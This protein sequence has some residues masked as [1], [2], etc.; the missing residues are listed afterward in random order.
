MIPLPVAGVEVPAG[1]VV[2]LGLFV[3]ALAGFFGVG[4]G[5]LLTPM[6]NALLGIPYGVAVGSSL[7]QMV[8][9]SASAGMRHARLRNI[10]YRLGLLLLLG[11]GLGAEAGAQVLEALKGAGD[12]VVFGRRFEAIGIVMSLTY[13]VLLT[14]IGWSVGRE[15][16]RC[17]HRPSD[18]PPEPSTPLMRALRRV[19]LRPLV[20][21]PASGIDA[22]SVWV[23]VVVGLVTGFFSGLL[24]VGGG[25]ILLPVLIYVI[26]CRTIVAIGTDLFQ[27]IFVA[28]YGALTHALKGNVDLALVGLMLLGS[29][30]GGH[31][32]AGLTRRFDATRLRG[33]FALLAFVGV[34]VVLWRLA[35]G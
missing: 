33:G 24:G 7:S 21:L 27:I 20:A 32:G 25:F 31:V 11:A 29:A 23:L 16:L 12:M 35:V 14:A 9:L 1:A 5:F 6:L 30:V 28:A 34:F 2:L 18:A 19:R 15:A 17:A 26:G 10:D 3:G 13:A 22:I 4:G 8:G